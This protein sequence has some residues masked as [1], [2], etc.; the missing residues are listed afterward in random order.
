MVNVCM[1]ILPAHPNHDQQLSWCKLLSCIMSAR[2]TVAHAPDPYNLATV[3][4][5]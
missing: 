1:H 3:L 4:Q 5:V 2:L